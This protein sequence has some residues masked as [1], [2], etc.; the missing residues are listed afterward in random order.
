MFFLLPIHA[1]DSMAARFDKLI[2]TQQS[3]MEL[4]VENLRDVAIAKDDSGDFIPIEDWSILKFDDDGNVKEI[5]MDETHVENYGNLFASIKEDRSIEEGGFDLG[6]TI[7]FQY[8]P[9]TALSLAIRDL[10]F[11]GTIETAQLPGG[12]EFL[13]LTGNKLTGTFCVEHLPKNL[14]KI[15]ICGN[16]FCGDLR[17]DCMPPA[18]ERFDAGDNQFSG[19]VDLSRLPS[20]LAMLDISENMLTGSIALLN[21]PKT[22]QTVRLHKNAF[23]ANV[24]MIIDKHHNL[25]FLRVDKRFRSQ[26]QLTNGEP[27]G[28]ISRMI[29]G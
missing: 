8:V 11:E 29:F 28:D 2:L 15:F 10:E 5:T 13:S 25:S 23:D 26:V 17:V 27:L 14:R 16:K 22:L 19:E 24:P 6:G 20:K 7:D 9:S 3:L 21:L 4:L 18:V 1:I 12:L